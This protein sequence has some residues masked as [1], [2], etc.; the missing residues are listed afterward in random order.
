MIFSKIFNRGMAFV[1]T[2]ILL[3]C[4]SCG[5]TT[6]SEKDSTNMDPDKSVSN[7]TY[8]QGLN[9]FFANI[10]IPKFTLQDALKK[11]ECNYTGFGLSQ[12]E[13][14]IIYEISFYMVCKSVNDRVVIDGETE[15]NSYYGSIVDNRITFRDKY[16]NA[17]LFE[18]SADDLAYFTYGDGIE[19]TLWIKDEIWEKIQ[20]ATPEIKYC[21]KDGTVLKMKYYRFPDS[22][23][24]KA[25]GDLEFENVSKGFWKRWIN[26]INNDCSG[27]FPLDNVTWKFQLKGNEDIEILAEFG[28]DYWLSPAMNWS[29]DKI[30][31]PSNAEKGLKEVVF[32]RQK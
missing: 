1:I 24:F 21:S 15:Y 5:A 29:P 7:R 16:D 2:E 22:N 12:V 25:F 3:L 17:I 8:D 11:G 9:S 19:K 6:V 27:Y 28:Q 30:V 10:E 14:P 26:A 31:F 13:S 32:I 4:N 20:K 23:V 18:A